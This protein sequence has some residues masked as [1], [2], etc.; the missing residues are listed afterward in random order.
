MASSMVSL[1]FGNEDGSRRFCF[2]SSRNLRSIFG[3]EVDE[4]YVKALHHRLRLDIFMYVKVPDPPPRP[5]MG[6]W[7][8]II[9]LHLSCHQ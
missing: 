4:R 3:L 6:G 7:L 5:R 8:N 1:H 2:S 9:F